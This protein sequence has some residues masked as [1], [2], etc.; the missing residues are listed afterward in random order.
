[1]SCP[2]CDEGQRNCRGPLERRVRYALNSSDGLTVSMHAS[3]EA[4]EKHVNQAHHR[5]SIAFLLLL[6]PGAVR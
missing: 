3:S 5:L 6:H 4:A 2:I 1:M